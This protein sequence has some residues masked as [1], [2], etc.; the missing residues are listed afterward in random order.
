[1]T[2]FVSNIQSWLTELQCSNIPSNEELF[3]KLEISAGTYKEED[4]QDG[5]SSMLRIVPTVFGERFQPDSLASVTNISCSNCS[6]GSITFSLYEGII[7][8]MYELLPTD[9]L[10]SHDVQTIV[11]TGGMLSSS[12]LLQELVH[13]IFRLPIRILARDAD[14]AFGATLFLDE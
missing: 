5:E 3:K 13:K 12:K 8:N 9:L 2:T 6:L 4:H 10:L 14:A 1:M 7:R 11:T